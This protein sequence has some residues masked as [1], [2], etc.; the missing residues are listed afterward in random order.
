MRYSGIITFHPD[1]IGK[2]HQPSRL[3]LAGGTRQ[4]TRVA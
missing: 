2:F 4:R 3:L 1:E